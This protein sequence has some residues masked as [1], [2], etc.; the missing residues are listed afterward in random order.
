MNNG[1]CIE[2][3]SDFSNITH[4]CDCGFYYYGASCEHKKD[5]C[6]NE[7][8]SNNGQCIDTNNEAICVCY[9]LFSG[10]KCETAS[11]ELKTIKTF[12]S[13]ASIIAIAVVILFYLII[14]SSDF[15]NF[16]MKTK[17]S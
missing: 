1:T 6:Q 17:R 10:S 16:L 7:T 4:Y 15:I 3:L 11:E 12:I 9:S 2:D 5:I 13:I 14:I 8:C